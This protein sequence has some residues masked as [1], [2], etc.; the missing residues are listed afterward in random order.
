MTLEKLKN[1]FIAHGCDK[2]YIK[3]LSANDNSKNQVYLSGSYDILNIFPISEVKEEPS[4]DWQK[5]G[6][7]QLSGLG[8]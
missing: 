6:S 7:K 2:V 5:K 3:T 1:I 8:G 4:G